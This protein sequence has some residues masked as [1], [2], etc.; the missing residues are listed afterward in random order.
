M[1]I[2]YHIAAALPGFRQWRDMMITAEVGFSTPLARQTV[3][4]VIHG[5]LRPVTTMKL[6]A[7][8]RTVHGPGTGCVTHSARGLGTPQG[9]PT[10][11]ATADAGRA[12]SE[13]CGT[14]DWD[15]CGTGSGSRFPSLRMAWR[16]PSLGNAISHSP[17][18]DPAV[19]RC[20]FRRRRLADGGRQWRTDG[21]YRARAA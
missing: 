1:L 16:S 6:W 18:P 13:S 8:A 20:R 5:N 11:R 10:G 17:N 9:E 12:G 21:H 15:I 7:S 3:W 2:G 14:A 19:V 4:K